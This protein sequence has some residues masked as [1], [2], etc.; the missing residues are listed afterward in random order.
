[1]KEQFYRITYN[2]IGIYQAL[3]N[4]ITFDQWKQLLK[5]DSVFKWLPKPPKY[6]NH[7]YSYFTLEGYILFKMKVLPVCEQYLDKSQIKVEKFEGLEGR[8][9]Y[10][11]M[12]QVVVDNTIFEDVFNKT[13]NSVINP[14]SKQLKPLEQ[15]E[16]GCLYEDGSLITNMDEI[17]ERDGD[18]III[19]T[20]N[21]FIKNKIG[22]C[23]D[24][25][26]YINQLCNEKSVENKCVYLT[27]NLAPHYPTHSFNVIKLLNNKWQV[28][29]VFATNNCLWKGPFNS[30]EEAINER[31]KSWIEV[32][33]NGDSNIEI[34]NGENMPQG[35]CNMVEYYHKLVK[36][37]SVYNI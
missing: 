19:Q 4:N 21:S 9:V 17:E 28:I 26:V 10:R 23:H 35:G 29:D 20:P 6:T 14:L 25:T 5:N 33:N 15:F 22:M 13:F 7:Y 11:D 37:F 27:S 3:K 16:Y 1:M 34:L 30:Y 12:Y 32:D 8:V 2:N 18:T 24:A 36:V 31:I